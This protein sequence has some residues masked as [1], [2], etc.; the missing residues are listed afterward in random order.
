MGDHTT[1]C[2]LFIMPNLSHFNHVQSST[3][4][5]SKLQEMGTHLT[6]VLIALNCIDITNI[7]SN[8]EAE[9]DEVSGLIC[10]SCIGH[11]IPEG[12]DPSFWQA[13]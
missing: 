5:S 2:P 1:G 3:V 7:L 12:Y 9:L 6:F 4:K 8:S 10:R 11:S 13:F